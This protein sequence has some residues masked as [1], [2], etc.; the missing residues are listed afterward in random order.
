MTMYEYL[1]ELD[2][3][4]TLKASN[5]ELMTDILIT[6]ERFDK[7]DDEYNEAYEIR[8]LIDY[9]GSLH[10]LIDSNIDIYNYDLRKWS[11]DNYDYVSQ[12]IEEGLTEG[13]TDFHK[14]IQSGQYC[15]YSEVANEA[16][17]EIAN[18]INEVL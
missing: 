9:D 3:L 16:L 2:V 15:Y 5:N 17:E 1:K 13:V 18:A 8:E 6:L 14:L 7:Q 10:S 4:E 12:A 11:V